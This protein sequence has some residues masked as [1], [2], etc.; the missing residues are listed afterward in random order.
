MKSLAEKS[1]SM[2]QKQV[3]LPTYVDSPNYQAVYYDYTGWDT[4]DTKWEKEQLEKVS[5]FVY[6]IYWFGKSLLLC[7]FCPYLNF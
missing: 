3:Q 5:E 7:S 6:W 4:A 1:A 2:L